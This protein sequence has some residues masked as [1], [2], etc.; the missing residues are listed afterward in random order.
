M[1]DKKVEIEKKALLVTFNWVKRVIELTDFNIV[2]TTNK[3]ITV[4]KNDKWY[5]C[6]VGQDYYI[7]KWDYALILDIENKDAIIKEFV[8]GVIKDLEWG[9]K[10]TVEDAESKQKL[11]N[12]FIAEYGKFL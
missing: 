9:I 2:T 8:T 6:R 4:N 11:L 10:K 1:R 12:I 5:Y 3:N 7:S